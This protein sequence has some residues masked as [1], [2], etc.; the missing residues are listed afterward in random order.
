MDRVEFRSEPVRETIVHL[1]KTLALDA[2]API[3]R[4]RR[5]SDSVS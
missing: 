3:E 1:V 4:L 2:D 5:R